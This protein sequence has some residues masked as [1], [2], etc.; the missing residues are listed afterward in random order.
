MTTLFEQTPLFITEGLVTLLPFGRLADPHD[1]DRRHFVFRAVGG[2][3]GVVSGDDVGDRFREVASGV[4]HTRRS[5]ER[6]VGKEWVSTCR[7][8]WTP[9]HKQKKIHVTIVETR[10][11]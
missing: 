6:R 4:D 9:Y 5:E 10:T 3:V 8:R 2:P 11:Q 7:Y 1:L